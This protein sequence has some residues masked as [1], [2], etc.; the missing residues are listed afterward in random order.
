ME[1]GMFQLMFRL[2]LPIESFSNV[3]IYPSNVEIDQR[4]CINHI[5]HEHYIYLALLHIDRSIDQDIIVQTSPYGYK[6]NNT[7]GLPANIKLSCGPN[8][9]QTSYVVNCNTVAV[10]SGKPEIAP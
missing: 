9:M 8:R 3:I 2:M 10:A 1:T 7:S 4:I 6:P 5:N